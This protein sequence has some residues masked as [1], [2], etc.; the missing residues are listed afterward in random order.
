[1][2]KAGILIFMVCLFFTSCDIG[3]RNTNKWLLGTWR[4]DQGHVNFRLGD[5][6][7][8]LKEGNGRIILNNDG[9]G[10]V[11]N[12]K[13]LFSINDNI[14]GTNII[15]FSGEYNTDTQ[16]YTIHKITNKRIVF[17]STLGNTVHHFRKVQ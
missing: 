1:M 14:L 5:E 7:T 17:V 4:F 12:E 2:K 9:T 8:N 16:S 11:N 13:F 15:L 3:N 6:R 10:T